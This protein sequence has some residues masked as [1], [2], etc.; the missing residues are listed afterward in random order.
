MEGR[1]VIGRGRDLNWPDS[2]AAVCSCFLKCDPDVLP[3]RTISD[4]KKKGI[5]V[6]VLPLTL[7]AWI[8]K[9]TNADRRL[10]ARIIHLQLLGHKQV[11]VTLQLK[12]Q[13]TVI[14]NWLKSSNNT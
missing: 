10:F 5:G 7:L 3:C 6:R 12:E 9:G 11:R 14:N 8:S 2:P 4:G 13:E 1:L